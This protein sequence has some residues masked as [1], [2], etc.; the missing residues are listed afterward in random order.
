[1][2]RLITSIAILALA[3]NVHAQEGNCEQAQAEAFL[4]VNNVRARIFN[5]GA[6]FWRGSPNVYAVPQNDGINAIFAASI[7]IGGLVDEELRMA[8][9]TYGSWEYWPGP[10]DASGNAPTDCSIYDRIYSVYERDINSYEQTG[11]ATADLVEWPWELGAPVIDGDGDPN[12]YNLAGGDRPEI[13]G[14]QTLWWVMNDRGNLHL[15]T[16]TD[17]MG[18]EVQVTAF[19]A[20]SDSVHINNAT[21]YRYKLIYKG[22]Q[23]IED[24]YFNVFMD[25]DLGNFDDDYVG[26]D[27]T[28][29]I[30]YTYNADN[31]DEGGG[32]YGTAPPAVGIDMM[33]GAL[34]DNDGLDNNQNGEIDEPGERL[35][36]TAYHYFDGGS[37]LT[38]DPV[39]GPDFYNYM[40]GRWRDG[41][42][43]TLGGNGRDFSDTPIP[44]AYPGDPVTGEGWTEGNPGIDGSLPPTPPADRRS[45]TVTGPFTMQPGDTQ[46]IVFAVI[47]G[48]GDDHLDSI[49]SLREASVEVQNAFESGFD[50]PFPTFTSLTRATLISPANTV[51]N[52]PVDPLF[53]W[54]A[55]NENSTFELQLSTN[56]EFSTVERSDLVTASNFRVT[57]LTPFTT[58]FWRVRQLNAA[59]KGPWSET[60]TFTTTDQ[61]VGSNFLNI[62]GFMTTQN[63]AG[64]IEPPDMAAFAFEASGFPILEGNLTPEGA[65]PDPERPTSGVQQ[66]TNASAWGIHTGGTERRLFSD[67]NGQGFIE[68]SLRS[69]VGTPFAILGSDYEW[70][71]TQACLDAID[72][73]I[74]EGDCLAFRA[75]GDGAF[76]EVPFALWATGDSEDVMDDYRLVPILCEETCGAGTTA[77]LFDIGQDHAISDGADDPFSDWVYW[78]NPDPT[79]TPGEQAYNDFFFANGEAGLELF[80]RTVLVQLDGGT[81]APYDVALPEPGTTFRIV[82]DELAAPLLS[83]PPNNDIR[84]ITSSFLSWQSLPGAVFQLQ[85][86][87]EP[88]FESPD[89][90]LTGLTVAAYE[91]GDY[92]KNATYYWRVRMTGANDV[93]ASE[94]SETWQFTIPLN[95]DTDQPS[96]ILDFALEQSYPNPFQSATTIRYALPDAAE[97]KLEVF[98]TLGRRVHVLE[99]G[100]KPAGWH[101]AMFDAT[102]LSNGTYFY[103]LTAGSF[104]DTKSMVLLR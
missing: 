11:E 82:L 94:W 39:T 40:Q 27:T 20:A 73:N 63:A 41:Q 88:T 96:E 1:M 98:D 35:F 28:L 52:Q 32:G 85:I 83:S 18:M 21:L 10:L 25:V 104:S 55:P 19:S 54:E 89:L 61:E 59:E 71:F 76:I 68:R 24:V 44:F 102:S 14:H 97:V 80:A 79:R 46:E 48:R 67:D 26:S 74:T 72:N 84:P 70:R 17:P 58:Y 7:W 99:N 56:L 38:G 95:V 31:E 62:A 15:R 103:R 75:F 36:M 3:T 57:D 81:E 23:P 5:N 66:S 33:Q 90:D 93:P 12:N 9:S 51:S 78:Y 37:I 91:T 60:W 47:W 64:A 53:R 13:M 34:V 101:E 49:T 77:G 4:D 92:P 8:G 22:D 65:Y 100:L 50:V 29:N 6:L 42:P 2:K 86:D 45:G 43:I 30:G 69:S 87:T 16:E